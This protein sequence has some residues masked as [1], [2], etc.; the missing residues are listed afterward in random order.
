[1]QATECSSGNS[2]IVDGWSIG[3]THLENNCCIVK[4]IKEFTS[5][6]AA[7]IDVRMHI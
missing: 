6:D 3:K 4:N 1:M 2:S 5:L 7:I